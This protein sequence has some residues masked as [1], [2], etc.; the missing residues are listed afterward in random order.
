M[1]YRNEDDKCYGVAGM[2]IGLSIFD[3]DD[4][5]TGITLDADGLDC[6]EFTPDF[7][8]CGNPRFSP[9]DTWRCLYSH[10]TISMG[11]VIA[12][13]MCRKM[14]LDHGVI[15][16][17]LRKSLL[18]VACD[19]GKEMC[20]LDKDEVEEIFDQYFSHLF[21][22][23]SNENVKIAVHQLIKE[24]KERHNFSRIELNDLLHELSIA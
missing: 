16:K 4:L 15:D 12:N 19:E 1:K 23:F 18:Q 9:K 8:F 3:A 17:K 14:L 24:L 7:F 22:V 2:A 5:F 10:Y 6:I 20:Q 13:T 11:L 21:K